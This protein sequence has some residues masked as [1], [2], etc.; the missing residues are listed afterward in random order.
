LSRVSAGDF[1]TA[2]V[3]AGSLLRPVG[4]W[5]ADRIGGYRLLIGVLAVFSLCFA[6]VTAAS[7][8]NVALVLLFVGMGI[9]GMGNGAVFQIVPQ[10]FPQNMGII[11]G[12]VGA[13]GG[14]GGFFLP[15]L[16]GAIKDR[17]GE[18]T[19]GLWMIAA[20]FLVGAF[21]LL[22][23]GARWWKNWPAGAVQRAGIFAYR[24]KDARAIDG[25][26]A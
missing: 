15:T 22:E 13:A 8:V 10:R 14:V 23:L 4:G 7:S 11:T 18:Y 16:L 24:S 9:L 5:L 26:P 2:V 17:T 12:I 21:V 1:T 20:V 25:D 3:V 19:L 6:S